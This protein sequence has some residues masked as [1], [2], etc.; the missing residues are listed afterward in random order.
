MPQLSSCRVGLSL[1]SL[2]VLALGACSGQ[3]TSTHPTTAHDANALIVCLPSDDDGG[4]GNIVPP[5][6]PFSIS[7]LRIPIRA[8]TDSCVATQRLHVP[9]P[10]DGVLVTHLVAITLVP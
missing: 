6:P 8:A 2:A 3:S 10:A 9:E 1:L 4:G 5:P 7:S